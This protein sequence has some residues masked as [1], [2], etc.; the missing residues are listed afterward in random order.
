[1]TGRLSSVP[2]HGLQQ[3]HPTVLPT[4]ELTPDIV[5]D[6]NEIRV[7]SVAS[8][9]WP[10]VELNSDRAAYNHGRPVMMEDDHSRQFGREFLKHPLSIPTDSRLVAACELLAVRCKQTTA[11]VACAIVDLAVPLHRILRSRLD[12]TSS[13]IPETVDAVLWAANR[14]GDDWEFYWNGYYSG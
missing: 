1:M 2:A 5:A 8:T 10:E 3:V 6:Q 4:L 14:E 11:C 12:N 9:V 7:G 13:P